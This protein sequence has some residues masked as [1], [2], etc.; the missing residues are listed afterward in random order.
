MGRARVNYVTAAGDPAAMSPGI[1]LQPLV[2]IMDLFVILPI[3]SVFTGVG[4]AYGLLLGQR[5]IRQIYRELDTAWLKVS[6]QALVIDK[7][8]RTIDKLLQRPQPVAS[9]EAGGNRS[10]PSG[11]SRS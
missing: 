3:L 9:C 10:A 11:R 4:A 8:A 6:R 7:Q 2:A 1:N 5:R